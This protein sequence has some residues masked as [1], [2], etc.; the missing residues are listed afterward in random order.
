[1]KSKRNHPL[2]GVVKHS[3]LNKIYYKLE[4]GPLDGAMV[5]LSRP[6]TLPMTCNGRTGFYNSDNIWEAK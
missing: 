2:K 4:G 3:K 5:L 6:G 1:M